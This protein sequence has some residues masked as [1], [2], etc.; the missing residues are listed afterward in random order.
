MYG[1]LCRADT[2]THAFLTV[3]EASSNWVRCTGNRSGRTHLRQ[4]RKFAAQ[5]SLKASF[6]AES[7]STLKELTYCGKFPTNLRINC[8]T[9]ADVLDMRVAPNFEGWERYP[10]NLD[11]GGQNGYRYD[12]N[13]YHEQ[14][15]SDSERLFIPGGNLTLKVIESGREGW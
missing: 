7:K 4:P 3:T 1:A 15:K 13:S 5:L 12:C 10:E 14:L 2:P 8:K 6:L 11:L 9:Y